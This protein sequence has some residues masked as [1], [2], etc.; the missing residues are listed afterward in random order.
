MKYHWS[1]NKMRAAWCAALR[2]DWARTRR[3]RMLRT[4]YGKIRRATPQWADLEAIDR[5]YQVAKILGAHV[6]HI[7]P[8]SSPIVCG[9][10]VEA[11]L[12]LTQPSENREKSNRHW[13]D[14]PAC[15]TC[16][17]LQMDVLSHST[18]VAEATRT[19]STAVPLDRTSRSV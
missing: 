16:G 7:V 4:R 12:R 13:P 10:H 2:E 9:L 17:T 8:L 3:E 1:Q 11:N 18:G 6:D 14:M 5:L 19:S 15:P